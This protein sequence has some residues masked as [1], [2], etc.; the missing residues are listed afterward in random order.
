MM[1]EM[2][3]SNSE[4]LEE[5]NYLKLIMKYRL[6]LPFIGIVLLLI[7]AIS[8]IGESIYYIPFLIL[9][10][11][12]ILIWSGWLGSFF[13]KKRYGWRIMGLI[14]ELMNFS[15]IV[16]LFGS[17]IAV[18]NINNTLG[19]AVVFI[20]MILAL[21]FGSG[22]MINTF[23]RGVKGLKISKYFNPFIGFISV[24]FID[25]G[26]NWFFIEAFIVLN[27]E[28][29][30]FTSISITVF[31]IMLL[32]VGGIYNFFFLLHDVRVLLTDRRMLK[33]ERETH[34]EIDIEEHHSEP[35]KQTTVGFCPICG[36]DI[37]LAQ[38]ACPNCGNLIK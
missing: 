34:S 29:I 16:V 15:F 28:E 32:L 20:S 35:E 10:G 9:G 3:S 31:G 7:S 11:S 24:I 4:L 18:A 13:I 30:S 26:V 14:G 19:A 37:K 36:E 27:L 6:Y 25:V 8:Y 22:W 2:N 21:H 38:K 23:P 1:D 17:L 5:N 33:L 12:V